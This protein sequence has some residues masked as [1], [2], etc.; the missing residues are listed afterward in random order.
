[1]HNEKETTVSNP[2][3]FYSSSSSQR[4]S[5]TLDCPTRQQISLNLYMSQNLASFPLTTL[6]NVLSSSCYTEYVVFELSRGQS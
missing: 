5:K 4:K 3:W 2:M 6:M 1:M